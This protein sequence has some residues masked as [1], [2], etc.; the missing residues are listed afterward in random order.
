[1]RQCSL[2]VA[3]KENKILLLILLF[4]FR[5][6]DSEDAGGIVVHSFCHFNVLW[7][8]MKGKEQVQSRYDHNCFFVGCASF[9]SY[10]VG[11]SFAV[12]RR[13]SNIHTVVHVKPFSGKWKRKVQ[14]WCCWERSIRNCLLIQ[15]EAG[16]KTHGW[17]SIF[18]ANRADRLIKAQAWEKSPKINCLVMAFLPCTWKK[19][20]VTMRIVLWITKES[21]GGGT[22]FLAKALLRKKNNAPPSMALDHL[23]ETDLKW[24]PPVLHPSKL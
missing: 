24:L 18:S 4:G 20:E 1:M 21:S 11:D 2:Y 9:Q 3:F 6:S 8:K 15:V 12:V 13:Q 17:W 10:L 22:L 23:G 5:V 7:S 19:I 14:D 16:E